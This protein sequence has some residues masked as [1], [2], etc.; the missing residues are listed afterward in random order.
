MCA[1]KSEKNKNKFK[2]E[3]LE[4]KVVANKQVK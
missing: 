3:M 1:A 2:A 4:H